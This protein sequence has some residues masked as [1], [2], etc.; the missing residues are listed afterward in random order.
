[1]KIEWNLKNRRRIEKS[2]G[3]KGKEGRSE[4]NGGEGRLRNS[5]GG[6]KGRFWKKGFRDWSEGYG[7]E[8][9]EKWNWRNSN[10]WLKEFLRDMER[11]RG[12][13]G[14]GNWRNGNVK[15][16]WKSWEKRRK[17]EDDRKK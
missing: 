17:K 5:E 14:K 7:G 13:E 6:R 15:K 8:W 10:K 11:S 2:E 12:D 3:W 4:G 16:I 9:E 1:M